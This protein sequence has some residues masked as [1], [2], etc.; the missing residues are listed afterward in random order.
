MLGGEACLWSELV[1]ARILDLRLWERL[2]AIAERLWSPADC[3]DV[4]AL[5]WRLETFV[6]RLARFTVVN[7]EAERA[8]RLSELG[9]N[10]TDQRNLQP[11]FDAVECTK[12]YSRLLGER[13]LRAR[14]EGAPAV[15][16]RPYSTATVLDRMADIL[17]VESTAAAKLDVMIERLIRNRAH[18][19]TRRGL[20]SLAR[21]WRNQAARFEPIAARVP[22]VRELAP[23]SAQLGEL[24]DILDRAVVAQ[25]DAR[26]THRL[27]ELAQPS[28]E[29]LLAV[30]PAI[31]RLANA[32]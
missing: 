28:G 10:A 16:E 19:A 14:V 23:L 17:P 26:D 21:R 30:V 13:A 31:A 7:V 27:T 2:P 20:A 11:L 3:V 12:W 24:A 25:C 1:D 4:A 5:R 9:I 6:A 8:S 15:V 32:A 22:T 18:G 29:Y